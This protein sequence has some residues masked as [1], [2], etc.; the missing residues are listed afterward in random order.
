MFGF[1]CK[2]FGRNATLKD[3]EDVVLERRNVFTE[4][5]IIREVIAQNVIKSK[6]RLFNFYFL[7]A[8]YVD[9]FHL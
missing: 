6:I 4:K 7:R 8:R 3:A 9:I 2:I 5:L 1:D